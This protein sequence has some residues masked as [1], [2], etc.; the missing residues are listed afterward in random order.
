MS[1]TERLLEE[2]ANEPRILNDFSYTLRKSGLFGTLQEIRTLPIILGCGDSLIAGKLVERLMAEKPLAINP[3]EL[4]LTHKIDPR[5]SYI[6]VSISG[7]TRMN[8]R[9]AS[10][11]KK[12]HARLIVVTAN[13][14][15]E[16]AKNSPEVLSLPY[17]AKWRVPGTLSYVLSV[18][19]LFS[20][21]GRQVRLA[22]SSARWERFSKRAATAARK[23]RKS[24]NLFFVGAGQSYAT[25][26]YAQAKVFESIGAKAHAQETEEFCHTH[27]FCLEK[28]RDTSVIFLKSP[29]DSKIRT[30]YSLLVNHGYNAQI[31]ESRS[32]ADEEAALELTLQVQYL[33]YHLMRLLGRSNFAFLENKE[34]LGISNRLIY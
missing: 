7:R 26:L 32:R 1:S 28:S 10:I 14:E 20:L 17:A 34:R 24:R 5:R 29:M 6:I 2:I 30:V 3:Y 18:A 11:I 22:E 16:L 8:I 9:A 4:L 31:I 27:L 33:I 25:S 21:F 12:S 23:T 15:S 19:A 13:P